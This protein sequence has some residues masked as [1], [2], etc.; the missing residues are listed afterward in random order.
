MAM[1]SPNW[2]DAIHATLGSCL[3]CLRQSSGDDETDNADSIRRPPRHLESL[4]RDT[5]DATDTEAE[6]VSLH[7]NV[8]NPSRAQNN[9]KKSKKKRSTGGASIT[10]FGFDLFGRRTGAIRLPDSDEEDGE[11]EN[12]RRRERRTQRGT[13][14]SSSLTFDSDAAS[15]DPATIDQLTP[16]QLAERARIAEAEA[17]EARARANAA[18]EE[19]RRE[20]EERRRKRRERKEL[21]RMA[22][23]L[24]RNENGSGE[25]EGFQGSGDV[26]PQLYIPPN[27]HTVEQRPINPQDPGSEAEADADEAVDLGGGLYASRNYRNKG[28]SGGDSDSRSR[29]SAS[30]SETSNSVASP[31][32]QHSPSPY[33]PERQQQ[34]V[35]GYQVQAGP[36]PHAYPQQQLYAPQAPLSLPALQTLDAASSSVKKKKKSSSS[37]KSRSKSSKS[38]EASSISHTTSTSIQS[39]SLA[40]PTSTTGAT[41][42]FVRESSELTETDHHSHSLSSPV[43]QKKPRA[44]NAYDEMSLGI[45]EPDELD[46]LDE[47]GV[48]PDRVGGDAVLVDV[49]RGFPSTGFGTRGPRG[50]GVKVGAFLANVGNGNR[51]RRSMSP[52]LDI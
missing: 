4:L 51:E 27:P 2:S 3:A 7:S 35:H 49:D 11:E 39:P 20:K 19:R 26:I 10:L 12:S 8:G 31:Y 29:T 14:R 42:P 21:K 15:L 45:D 33:T 30:R 1:H 24:A 37:H 47:F 6:T 28:G 34:F 52:D 41:L 23:A 32:Y 48:D 5:Q 44:N 22:E 9:R 18:E 46:E 38:S 36:H 16:E 25:F 50:T 40:S 43:I 17:L 13:T